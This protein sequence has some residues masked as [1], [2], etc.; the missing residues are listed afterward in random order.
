[1]A[2]VVRIFDT[3]LRDGEQSPGASMGPAQKVEVARQLDLLGVDVIEAGFPAASPG[4]LEAVT[5]VSKTV[6]TAEVAALARCTPGDV[7]AAARALEP[8]Q[9]PVLHVFMATSDIHLKH[10][11]CMSRTTVIQA[12]ARMVVYARQFCSRVEFSAEDATRS[13][14]DYLACV[15]DAA[16]Q[17]GADTINLPDT[18]G[19]A[20]PEE[21]AAMF[22]YVRERVHNSENIVFSAHCHDDLGM[23]TA[24]TL[25]A[26]GAGARQVEVTMNGLGERAGNAPLEEVVMALRTRRDAFGSPTV[27]INTRELVPASRMVSQMTGVAVQVN[28]AIVGANAFAHEAGIHQDGFIKERSTYEIM[29]P[30]DVG[31]ER[32]RLVLGK[33]SGRHGVAYRLSQLGFELDRSALDELYAHFVQVADGE[34]EVDDD[35]LRALVAQVRVH[36]AGVARVQTA[37][38]GGTGA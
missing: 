9:R 24:N 1:M 32:T 20:V 17:A 27:S 8:A 28:K 33:H 30:V 6:R 34:K 14:W 3:T 19:Y 15:C 11:L 22:R 25:A 26:V 12:V 37:Y 4:D 21:Y 16:V 35:G 10:K 23:A 38:A 18:V 7:E 2:N 13:D 36:A 29:Q 5:M 31:W